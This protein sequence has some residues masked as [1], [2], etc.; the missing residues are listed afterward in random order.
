MQRIGNSGFQPYKHRKNGKMKRDV[1]AFNR[2]EFVGRFSNCFR[3]GKLLA[4]RA[5]DHAYA[6]VFDSAGVFIA[7]RSQ[8][9]AAG[10]TEK[11]AILKAYTPLDPGVRAARIVS[12]ES[13]SAGL[14]A[15]TADQQTRLLSLLASYAGKFGFGAI[16]VVRNYTTAELLASLEVRLA[17]DNETEMLTTY[18][19]VERLAEI[20]VEACFS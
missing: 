15:M 16:F 4:E 2:D 11:L 18:R 12:D 6:P 10:S 20:Q 13:R 3:D 19:E 8:F 9:R 7:L 1:L 5:Y 14:G 17:S